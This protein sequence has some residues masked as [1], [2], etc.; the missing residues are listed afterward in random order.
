VA[1]IETTILSKVV[2]WLI[3]II[4]G[5]MVFVLRKLFV[6]G[7]TLSEHEK[8]LAL[9]DQRDKQWENRRR[10]ERQLRDTQRKEILK[11]IDDHHSL[12]MSKLD[13]LING[14]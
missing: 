6:Y 3:L 1:V 7:D 8:L 10:E 13:R 9:C 11:K 5:G 2:D 4:T 12:V 14:K